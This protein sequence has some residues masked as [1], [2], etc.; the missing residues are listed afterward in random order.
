MGN[1][2]DAL[3]LTLNNDFL[4]S[5]SCDGL[6]RVWDARSGRL[7]R[8]LKG[9]TG[10]VRAL[11]LILDGLILASGSEDMTIR[12][13]DLSSGRELGQL[14]GHTDTVTSLD[15][16]GLMLASGSDDGTFRIWDIGHRCEWARSTA[17]MGAV[18]AV[19]LT[20]NGRAL[21]SGSTD[22][23][24]RIWDLDKEIVVDKFYADA[25]ILNLALPATGKLA[26]ADKAGHIHLFQFHNRPQKETGRKLAA[27]DKS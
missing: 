17:Y 18:R 2:V 4:V 13:W 11:R 9:H 26:A 25:P 21:I 5:G 6:I 23:S 16:H 3:A 20:A 10:G 24:I 15:A 19:A 22:G 1:S 7:V 27:S 12:I 14:D 8:H